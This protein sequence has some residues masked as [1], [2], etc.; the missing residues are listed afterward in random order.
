MAVTTLTDTLKQVIEY[1]AEA[2]K[3]YTNKKVEE[4]VADLGKTKDELK[5]LIS[6]LDGLD[7]KEDGQVDAKVITAKVAELEATVKTL[8]DNISNQSAS[9]SDN[10]SKEI[11]TIKSDISDIKDNL[12]A[13]LTERVNTIEEKLANMEVDLNT[14]KSKVDELYADNSSANNNSTDNNSSTPAGLGL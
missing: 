2:Q 10:I 3:N 7:F 1:L 13:K 5:N 8:Q 6:A 14:L 12:I 11:E 4:F 9:V